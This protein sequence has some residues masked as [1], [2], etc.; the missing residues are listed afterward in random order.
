MLLAA[1]SAFAQG[2]S[3]AE[4]PEAAEEEESPKKL[5]P[6][7]YYLIDGTRN[8]SGGIAQG[9]TFMGALVTGADFDLGQIFSKSQGLQNVHFY[10]DT[11]GAFGRPSSGKTGDVQL[12]LNTW[13]P[14]TFRLYQ[15][16]VDKEWQ[17]K[18]G[19]KFSLRVGSQDIN[20]EF[21]LTDSSYFLTNSSFGLSP[22]FML[23]GPV[24]P[25]TFP[26]TSL[27]ARAA[28]TFSESF[29]V[30]AGAFDGVPADPNNI[31]RFNWDIGGDD[32]VMGIAEASLSG[33]I[34]GM[35][36]KA[37]V[38]AWGYSGVGGAGA[39]VLLEQRI[40][41]PRRGGVR[42][43]TAFARL[44]S[45][46]KEDNTLVDR[47]IAAGLTYTGIL[48]GRPEDK[49]AFGVAAARAGAATILKAEEELK[50]ITSFETA[51]ELA[52]RAQI[53]PNVFVMP[54]F[55]YIRSPSFQTDVADAV[56]GGVRLEVNL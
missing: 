17:L 29:K 26:Y 6:V 16:W 22:E 1:G 52:Y 33:K 36:G 38:G 43:L 55:Q 18:N 45:I 37:S 4:A 20:W 47:S 49:L 34:R 12:A 25:S 11:F 32:G 56:T 24:G 19:T 7:L 46:L 54:D 5:K 39:Y 3:E 9:N 13:S 51:W 41:E 50:T 48:A 28:W 27:G 15:M 14:E 42:G 30:M 35:S 53:R 10:I 40:Y 21:Q 23:A 44:G 2:V 31:D 8:F